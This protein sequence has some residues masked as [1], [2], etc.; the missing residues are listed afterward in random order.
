[1]S[2]HY[3]RY[4]LDV[5]TS[6]IKFT[7]RDAGSNDPVDVGVEFDGNFHGYAIH[8]TKIV[9][10]QNGE[11]TIH[12]KALR[13]K[14]TIWFSVFVV[15]IMWILT[16]IMFIL[17]LKFLFNRTIEVYA[18]LVSLYGVVLFS[19]PS[20][21]SAQPNIPSIGITIDIIGFVWNMFG[22]SV[23]FII[24]LLVMLG[25]NKKKEAEGTTIQPPVEKL[26]KDIP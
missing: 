15:A 1:M 8:H 26:K 22:V 6:D 7:I 19:L 23:G 3:T 24:V 9:R 17:S 12:F 4:P 20:I 2:G 5:H 14:T 10:E 25:R 11:I 16:I 18:D 13:S 21:R